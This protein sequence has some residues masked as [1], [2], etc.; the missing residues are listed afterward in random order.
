MS[1]FNLQLRQA[2]SGIDPVVADYALGYFN[3]ISNSTEDA[4]LAQQLDIPK[5]IA[6]LTE[7]LISA[8][9]DPI[10]VDKLSEKLSETFSKKLKDNMAKLSIT[11]DTSKRLLDINLIHNHQRDL[12]SSLAL[13]QSTTDLEHTGRIMETRVDKKKLQKAEAKIA[14]KVAKRNNKFVKYEASKLINESKQEDYDSFFMKVNPIEFGA[15]AGKSKDIK[16]DTFDLYVGAGQRILSDA[17][18]TLAF[19]RRYGL[20]GQ[21]GI[22]KST[23]LRALSRRELDIPKHITILHVEQEI[24]GDDTPALQSVLDADVWRKQ[25]L[26]EQSKLNERMTEI[27]TLKKEFEEESL[28][29]RKLENELADLEQKLEDVYEKLGEMESDKAEE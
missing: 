11:G 10:K 20:V 3:H 23:L 13:L 6:F 7:L 19:G 28:E 2:A 14:K 17:Q 9:G 8:G 5:E 1:N 29:M 16:L 25:L 21:N 27:D 4:V 15:G 24:R 12:D 22:G 18:L 26:M